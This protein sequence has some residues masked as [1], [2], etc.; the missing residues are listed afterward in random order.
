MSMQRLDQGELGRSQT[1]RAYRQW[2]LDERLFL[3]PLNDLGSHLAAVADDLMLPGITEG[4][5]ERPGDYSPPP[6]IGF[7]NQMKQGYA[8]ARYLLFEEMS[9]TC[10]HLSDRGVVL[11]LP[12]RVTLKA[13]SRIAARK[14]SITS[15]LVALSGTGIAF[16]VQG[17][18]NHATEAA[19]KCGM[20]RGADFHQ[21]V[22][23][24]AVS[25]F[26]A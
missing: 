10:V 18:R 13:A 23:N 7:F 9:S 24:G 15:E 12:G 19:K 1:E 2:C 11:S 25:P 6:I 5:D 16:A 14:P 3:C 17:M 8:S 20:K 21:I 26:S 22:R 4:F